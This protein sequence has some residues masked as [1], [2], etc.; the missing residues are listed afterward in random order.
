[1]RAL[2]F[3]G[4][5]LLHI[6]CWLL[7]LIRGVSLTHPVLFSF[8]S[9]E[10]LFNTSW[11]FF[12]IWGVSLTHPML[13]LFLYG[14]FLLHIPR[15]R[16]FYLGSFSYTSRA[17]FIFIWGVSLTH[18]VLALILSADFLLHILCWFHFY[19]GSFSYTSPA[20]FI[21]I[22]G[23]S[24][25]HPALDSFLCGK[26]LLHIPCWLFLCGEF[27]LHIPCCL[28]FYAVSFS[29]TSGAVL[30]SMQGISYTSQ[31][32]FFFIL[33]NLFIY[34]YLRSFPYRSRGS[35]SCTCCSGLMFSRGGFVT[36]PKRP[37]FICAEF[38][39]HTLYWLLFIQGVVLHI[40][41]WRRFFFI[42]ILGSFFL[43][44]LGSFS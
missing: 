20:G 40:A 18:P 38:L 23:F 41:C 42:F 5:F 43:F 39:L 26:F 35:F 27:L 2:F 9:A 44:Y 21:F 24:L 33:F 28:H 11:S 22:W 32:G 7:F 31:A 37:S 25:T 8:L 12:F 10:S 13:T 30:I 6:P 29:Y 16:Q 19:R 36:H 15:W 3:C 34:F 1:M 14:E 17:Y 4:K